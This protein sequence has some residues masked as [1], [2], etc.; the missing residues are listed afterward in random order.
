MI[1]MYHSRITQSPICTRQ[2]LSID[3]RKSWIVLGLWCTSE[4][5]ASVSMDNLSATRVEGVIT[6]SIFCLS[7]FYTVAIWFMFLHS[8]LTFSLSISTFFNIMYRTRSYRTRKLAQY[9]HHCSFINVIQLLYTE[10][11]SYSKKNNSFEHSSLNLS[12]SLWAVY[13]RNRHKTSIIDT[14]GFITHFPI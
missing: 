1:H 5:R 8:K 3:Q 6:V 11:Y 2:Y 4:K 14:S 7:Q 10:A 13:I 12:T 9:A